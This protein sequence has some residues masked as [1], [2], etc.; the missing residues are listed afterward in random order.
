MTKQELEKQIAN[1]SKIAKNFDDTYIAICP[2][3]SFEK[4]ANLLNSDTFEYF[5]QF[6][7]SIL[8]DLNLILEDLEYPETIEKYKL[9]IDEI[10]NKAII[11]YSKITEKILLD[12]WNFYRDK[13]LGKDLKRLKLDLKLFNAKIELKFL[14]EELAILKS[15]SA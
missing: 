6:K 12:S 14:E 7:S 10:E 9:A 13:N 2:G 15:F 5:N 4:L 3:D 8:D 1:Y 11:D